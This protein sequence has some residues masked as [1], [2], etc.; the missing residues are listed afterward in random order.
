MITTFPPLTARPAWSTTLT[1][2]LVKQKRERAGK[3]P[4]R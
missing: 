4:K 2:M 3:K 1:Q